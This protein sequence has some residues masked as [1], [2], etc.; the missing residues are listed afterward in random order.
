MFLCNIYVWFFFQQANKAGKSYKVPL[1]T[2]Y[3]EEIS[4]SVEAALD[5]GNWKDYSKVE[6]KTYSTIFQRHRLLSPGYV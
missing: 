6:V 4:D 5:V 3:V 1:S 2:F